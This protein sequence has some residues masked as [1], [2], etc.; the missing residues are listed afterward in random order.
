VPRRVLSGRVGLGARARGAVL[1]A[2]AVA[3]FGALAVPA[4]AA[5]GDIATFAGTGSSGFSG[6][7]GPATS[8]QLR[9]PLAVSWLAD[10]SVLVAD[11]ENNR[12]RRIS[13]CGQIRTVAGTGSAGHSGD[14]GP[15][16][17]ARLNRPI[18]VEP[19][20]GGGFLIADLGNRRVRM[21]SST[22]IIT[23]VAG[24]GQEG[25]SGDGGQATSARL[26]APTGVAVA[27][28]GGLL[29]ADAGAHRIRRVSTG[30]T[31][32]TVAG[33]GTEGGTGDGGPAVSARL[34]VPVGLAALP[35][36]G[37]LVTEYGGHRV[38]RV[39]AG[40]I[41]ARVAGT[42][43]AGYSGDGGAAAAARINLPIGVST[44]ADGG[45][46]IA[47]TSNGRVRKVSA[48]GTITTVAGSAE[49]GYAGDG[50]P[51]VLA[52]L[53][54][55]AAAVENADGAILIADSE[56]NRL[57]MVEGR[58]PVSPSAPVGD[59]SLPTLSADVVVAT[60]RAVRLPVVCPPTATEGCAG[61]IRLIVHRRARRRAAASR[62][63]VIARG[64]FSMAAGEKKLVKVPLTRAGRRLL[65]K[66]RNLTVRAVVARRGGPNIGRSKQRTTLR[67]KRRRS[68][69]TRSGA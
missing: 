39:S 66:R 49:R 14:G 23:T 16:T 51:A 27:R 32:T 24:T 61:T 45:F 57:R 59:A 31:I 35:D 28:D 29:I 34:A 56:D 5:I 36:G 19:M 17:S 43:T 9:S 21:V 60:A 50:G 11:Y 63:V 68:R 69:A 47:D 12:V 22:G 37:F 7:G 18:D 53:R 46:L 44:T 65:R 54:S 41:I 1:L 10:G 38:R 52:R 15:A 2:C 13:P 58:P 55:P 40:G 67:L 62:V 3:T 64:R 42:G 25:T 26:H 48:G 30:G 6:D 33:T 4:Q 8:A 20:A